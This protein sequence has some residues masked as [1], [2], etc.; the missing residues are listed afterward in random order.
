MT[1]T[2]AAWLPEPPRE[3]QCPLRA[4][5]PGK[6]CRYVETFADRGFYEYRCKHCRRGVHVL[7]PAEAVRLHTIAE[8]HARKRA[9]L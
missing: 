9:E 6:L 5:V 3:V 4:D 7:S 8:M 1:A 2:D